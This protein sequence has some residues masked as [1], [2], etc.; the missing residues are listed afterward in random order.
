M[1][2]E[3]T[4]GDGHEGDFLGGGGCRR[5]PELRDGAL[6]LQ[7]PPCF[8]TSPKLSQALLKGSPKAAFSFFFNCRR[9]FIYL[10]QHFP[11]A[12]SPSRG[13]VCNNP[14]NLGSRMRMVVVVVLMVVIGRLRRFL[15]PR[16]SAAGF[17]QRLLLPH[18]TAAASTTTTASS[19]ASASGCTARLVS[20]SPQ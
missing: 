17:P 11:A 10:S 20:D 16:V 19:T 4:F 13:R 14:R 18:F 8:T 9:A 2:Q 6:L 7:P 3:L 5:T 15:S 1:R 12:I